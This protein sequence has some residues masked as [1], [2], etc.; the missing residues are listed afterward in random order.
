M[1]ATATARRSQRDGGMSGSDDIVSLFWQQWLEHQD[2]LYQCCLQFMNWNP[3][4][5]ED[6]LNEA[7]VKASQKVQKYASKI[8][9]LKAWMYQVT[10]NHCIDIIRKRSKKATAIE[11][12]E[13]VGDGEDL[14]TVTPTKTPEQALETD[15]G[16]TKIHDAIASLP[17][18]LR[19][20]SILYFYEELTYTDIAQRQG[21][22][23]DNACKR[24]SRARKILRT[25]LS[26]YLLGEEE[27]SRSASARKLSPTPPSQ[28]EKQFRQPGDD[29]CES[30]TP[31]PKEADE[32]VGVV[33]SVEP[34]LS[35]TPPSQGEKQFR[36]PGDDRCESR[37]PTPK[38][39][40]E[41]IQVVVGVKPVKGE[42]ESLEIKREKISEQAN[43]SGIQPV[44]KGGA[45]TALA[46]TSAEKETTIVS[47]DAKEQEVVK[48]LAPEMTQMQEI[49]VLKTFT[50]NKSTSARSTHR[51]WDRQIWAAT[52][53]AFREM[54]QGNALDRTIAGSTVTSSVAIAEQ[55]SPIG[56]SPPY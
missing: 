29:R 40:D 10:R 27:T 14:G 20:T 36:Q 5:A 37:T 55:S 35:P 6:A 4:E 15:E 51:K 31:T 52:W 23:Y 25:K 38:E 28:R 49:L 56:E 33:V 34:E 32:C 8:A 1:Y 39:A 11:S 50:G 2:T 21:I 43:E 41:C 18:G 13:W 54:F 45:V 30:R 12:I 53:S 24:I 26:G 17:E 19:E 47:A 3:T 7:M 48:L 16:Y 22:S 42:I 46:T 44:D 9:N